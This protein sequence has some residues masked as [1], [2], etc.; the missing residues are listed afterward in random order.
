MPKFRTI[1]EGRPYWYLDGS[2]DRFMI[3][4]EERVR[5]VTTCADIVLAE[6]NRN[7]NTDYKL[8]HCQNVIVRKLCVGRFRVHCNFSAKAKGEIR[9]KHFFAEAEFKDGSCTIIH[10]DLVR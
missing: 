1:P 4:G 10:H 2:G 9:Q 5:I 3:L 6:F 8:C 7:N